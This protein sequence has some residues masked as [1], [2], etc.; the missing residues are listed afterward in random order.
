M[1]DIMT[2]IETVVKKLEWAQRENRELQQK[3][4]PGSPDWHRH[5]TIDDKLH[6]SLA[7]LGQ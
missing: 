5:E 2:A 6:E 4:T 3:C 1:K 7:A